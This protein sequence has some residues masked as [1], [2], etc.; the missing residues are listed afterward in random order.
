MKKKQLRKSEAKTLNELLLKLYNFSFEKKETLEETEEGYK[1]IL[2]KGTPVFFYYD[3]IP[4]PTLKMCMDNCPL[5]KVVV[6]MGA[7]KFVTSGADIMRPGIT[8]IDND[9]EEGEFVAVIDE[10]NKK[11]LSIAKAIF[12]GKEI[13]KMEKGKVLEN[14]HYVGDNIWSMH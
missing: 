1:V 4:I 12:P 2:Q 10:N 3:N 6:D 14:I 5:K 11:P 8:S 7:V 9:I 13:E